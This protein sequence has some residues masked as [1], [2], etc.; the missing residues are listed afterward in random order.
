MHYQPQDHPPHSS[1]RQRVPKS[2]TS[3][4]QPNLQTSAPQYQ[5]VI[6]TTGATNPQEVRKASAISTPT[7]KILRSLSL[8][9]DLRF[10]VGASE[11]HP[12]KPGLLQAEDNLITPLT[13]AAAVSD[14]PGPALVS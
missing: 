4:L 5:S 8:I 9:P 3:Q 11:T 10:C 13:P 2:S 7:K 1:S 12:L 14:P 6:T